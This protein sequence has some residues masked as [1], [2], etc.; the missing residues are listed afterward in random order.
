MKTEYEEIVK[1]ITDADPREKLKGAFADIMKELKGG[2]KGHPAQATEIDPTAAKPTSAS[3]MRKAIE[4][5][6]HWRIDFAQAYVDGVEWKDALQ[7]APEGKPPGKGKGGGKDQK[8]KGKGKG[9]Y[10]GKNPQSEKG[11]KG[12]SA[13]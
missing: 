6:P 7:E 10:K 5:A 12:K 11:G 3:D 13:G 1:A 2:G 8:T 9:K 4:K